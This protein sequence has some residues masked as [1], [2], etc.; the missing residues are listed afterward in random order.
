MAS[1]LGPSYPD[2]PERNPDDS[3]SDS[4]AEEEEELEPFQQMEYQK[5]KTQRLLPPAPQP[6]PDHLRPA[7]HLAPPLKLS[8]TRPPGGCFPPSTPS[9][10][11]S[12]RHGMTKL[13]DSTDH[14]PV[15]VAGLGSFGPLR[16][17]MIA[18]ICVL[19]DRHSVLALA[20]SSR[21]LYQ[22]ANWDSKVW[23]E[24]VLKRWCGDF[25]FRVN[26]KLTTFYSNKG[27]DLPP[28]EL[29]ELL[30][31]QQ[32]PPP[33]P[34][35]PD[36][37]K[38]KPSTEL[39]TAGED[40]PYAQQHVT[41]S[42]KASTPCD[43]SKP[44]S[45]GT[46]SVSS[47]ENPG[48]SAANGSNPYETMS[49]SSSTSSLASNPY[50]AAIEHPTTEKYLRIPGFYSE[51]MYKEWY[52]SQVDLDGWYHDTGHVPRI[53]ASEVTLEQFRERFLKA[54]QPCIITDVVP[55]WPANAKWHPETLMEQYCETLIKVNEYNADEVRVKMT[56]R[57]YLIYMRENK[58]YKPMYVFDSSFQRRAPGLLQDFG[59]P[60][61]FWEDLFAALDEQHRPA[62]R[63]FLMG[64]ART[65]SP[66]HRD[67][68]GT[69]AW[70]AVTHGHK[71][72]AL[73]PPWMARVPG[74]NMD[75]SH[76]NSHKWWS[77][78]YPTLAPQDKPIEFIQ[79]PGDLIFIPSGWWHAVLNLDETLS[80]TQNFV[81]TENL[82]AVVH[83]LFYSN[84]Q[85]V[86][87][88]WRARLMSLRPELY[89]YI[90][91]RIAYESSIANAERVAALET[92][93]EEQQEAAEEREG[94]LQAEIERLKEMLSHAG[95]PLDAVAQYTA[96]AAKTKASED[97]NGDSSSAKGN[98]AP[99]ASKSTA[100][101]LARMVGGR[102]PQ[103][104]KKT[105]ASPFQAALPAQ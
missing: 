7:G 36:Y 14:D 85:G 59:I 24:H 93:L 32:T 9:S 55:T 66:F 98:G 45:D 48:K 33:P 58:E 12:L 83:S 52:L 62:F 40:N 8:P 39:A 46:S 94:E 56:M 10:T 64:C 54:S 53:R 19:A 63:W 4:E 76:P 6:K 49:T 103:K 73:Y 89:N 13:H 31:T 3:L 84:M 87:Q 82:D 92:E 95:V 44:S 57:D 1:T 70:N 25:I 5:L 81:N 2:V 60:Q 79:G 77:L 80:V 35:T 96:E 61:Y 102:G 105:T 97:E 100:S 86:L 26:W 28:P 27:M 72:W 16:D 47:E 74:Q 34:Q 18:R 71:R 20:S 21:A 67:P 29:V 68:N 38:P 101:Y 90:G 17:S 75:D 42:S 15:R 23:R 78:I 37:A 11:P 88:Y 65:G 22:I 30:K 51:A 99:S 50:A 43:S 104:K 69:S 41:T 91:D